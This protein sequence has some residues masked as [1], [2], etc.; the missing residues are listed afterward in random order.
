MSGKVVKIDGSGDTEDMTIVNV[1]HD[2]DAKTADA[3]EPLKSRGSQVK[4]QSKR[5][6]SPHT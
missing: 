4:M 3:A 2:L 6:M 5:T 1:A